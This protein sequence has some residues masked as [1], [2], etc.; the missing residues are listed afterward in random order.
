MIHEHQLRTLLLLG[1]AACASAAEANREG[2]GILLSGIAVE[3]AR[4]AAEEVLEGAEFIVRRTG[5]SEI[6]ATTGSGLAP[7][8]FGEFILCRRGENPSHAEMNLRP[9]NVGRPTGRF[10]V[11]IAPSDEGALLRVATDFTVQISREPSGRFRPRESGSIM[12]VACESTGGLEQ[13]IT[14]RVGTQTERS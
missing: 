12:H 4:R 2:D 13:R 9:T 11:R 5:P 1:L 8:G 7:D 10:V 14:A 3:E 6:V